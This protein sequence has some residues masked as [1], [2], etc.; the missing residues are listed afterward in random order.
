[1]ID[2]I[3]DRTDLSKVTRVEVIDAQGRSYTNWDVSFIRESLQDDG[4]TLK[5][6]ITQNNN[7]SK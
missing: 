7:S 6:F 2:Y 4:R 3:K 5:L 1:M